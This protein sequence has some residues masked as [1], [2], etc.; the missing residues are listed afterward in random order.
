MSSTPSINLSRELIGDVNI[1]P[2]PW[3]YFPWG[4]SWQAS[5]LGLWALNLLSVG[6]VMTD[7]HIGP[8]GP[9]TYFLWGEPWQA[10]TLGPVGPELTF[11]GVS[12][13][14]PP[15]WACGPWTPDAF[16]QASAAALSTSAPPAAKI[17]ITKQ[18][19][20]R[21]LCSG[22]GSELIAR[23]RTRSV[24]SSN[25]HNLFFKS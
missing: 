13:G 20:S 5:T 6:W 3:T 25:C 15:H 8:G 24:L 7:L 17:V 2:G 21:N 22:S 18:N 11:R 23:I 12:H 19:S 16:Q 1:G 4:E 9:W 14:R 10:S